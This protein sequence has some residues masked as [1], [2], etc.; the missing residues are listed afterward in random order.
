MSAYSEL[1]EGWRVY[2]GIIVALSAIAFFVWWTVRASDRHDAAVT[3]DWVTQCRDQGGRAIH[4]N[5]NYTCLVDGV[6]VGKRWE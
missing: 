4:L 2:L 1:K 6:V 3:R 5:E